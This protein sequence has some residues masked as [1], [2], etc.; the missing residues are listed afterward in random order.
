MLLL[1]PMD[2]RLEKG[3][4]SALIELLVIRHVFIL[5]IPPSDQRLSLNCVLL[6][7]H[8]LLRHNEQHLLRQHHAACKRCLASSSAPNVKITQG[9][10][11][12]VAP[13]SAAVLVPANLSTP[14]A[15]C[16]NQ[17]FPQKAP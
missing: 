6:R 3:E 15:G 12:P 16:S 1:A 9:S 13:L 17:Y 8:V 11:W 10:F 7:V 2:T 4:K 14:P 5:S